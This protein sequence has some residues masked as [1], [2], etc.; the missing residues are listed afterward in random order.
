ME[1][2][3][4]SASNTTQYRHVFLQFQKTN[5]KHYL[6]IPLPGDKERVKLLFAKHVATQEKDTRMEHVLEVPSL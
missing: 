5:Y 2:E 1:R 3:L 6:M 4:Q